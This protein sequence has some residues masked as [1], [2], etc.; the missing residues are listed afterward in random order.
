MAGFAHLCP[1]C[2]DVPTSQCGYRACPQR[3]LQTAAVTS[4]RPEIQSDWRGVPPVDP[5]ARTA[6]YA[7]PPLAAPAARPGPEPQPTAA[8]SPQGA[9]Q[10]AAS[11]IPG[12]RRPQEDRP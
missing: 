4:F 2:L 12:P 3:A 8:A 1:E 10:T 5:S 6:A 9:A 11:T 7:G